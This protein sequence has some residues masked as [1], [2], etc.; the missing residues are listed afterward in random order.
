MATNYD[1]NE[2]VNEKKWTCFV[3]HSYMVKKMTRYKMMKLHFKSG[4]RQTGSPLYWFPNMIR[5]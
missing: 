2:N 3:T 4:V 1:Q 5:R